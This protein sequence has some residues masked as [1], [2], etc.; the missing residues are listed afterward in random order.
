M[1][2]L[3]ARLANRRPWFVIAGAILFALV[4]GALGGS[5][6]SLLVGNGFA[7]PA[8]QSVAAQNRLQQATGVRA[9]TS[10]I[11]LVRTGQPIVSPVSRHE[12]ARVAGII[13][14]DPGIARVLTA[15]TAHD[16]R[17]V[18]RDGRGTYVEALF[19]PGSDEDKAAVRL[20]SRLAGDT[21]VQ[22]GGAAVANQEING[23]VSRDLGR[24]ELLAFPL[25]FLLLLWVFRG[26]VAASLPLI[27]G[28]LTILAAFLGLRIVVSFTPLSVYALNL[29]TGLGLGLSIDYSLFILSRF[30]EELAQRYDRHDAIRRTLAT[31]GR[32]V[33]FSSLTVGAALA[34]L[35]VFPERFLYS[36]G[37]GGVLV[38]LLASTMAL[39]VLPAVLVLLGTRVNSLAPRRWRRASETVTSHGFWWRLS[40]GVMRRPLPVAA[41][42]AVLLIALGLPALGIRFTSVDLSDLPAGSSARVVDRSLA[43]S[44]PGYVT[45]PVIVVAEAPLSHGAQV[46]ALARRLRAVPGL[47]SVSPPQPV[48]AGTWRIDATLRGTVFAAGS[49]D[50][51]SSIRSL[52]APFP[53][54]VGGSTANFV[55]L[56]ASLASHLP[57]AVLLIAGVSLV[58]LFLATGSVLLPIKSLLMNLLTLSAAY[59]LLVLVFQDG[60]LEGLLRYTG[61][62]AIE[63][64]QPILLFAIVFGLSTDYAVFLL[65]RIKE[66]HDGGVDTSQAVALGLERTGRIITAAALLF[67][68]AIGAFATSQIIFIKEL[69]VGTA[70]AVI[71]DATVVRALLVPSLMALLGRW[72][73]WAPSFLRRAHAAVGLDETRSEPEPVSA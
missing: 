60:R 43:A 47:A 29:V 26:L 62:G 55:D 22:L 69:G 34:S 23:I 32:T 44:F 6:S 1:L 13:A 37:I 8:S 59:G 2:Q 19:K 24:A 21:R 65:T 12:V 71:L 40:H 58:L 18:S 42:S 46:R 3:S 53:V 28:A 54:L 72:N 9:D 73:W 50:A 31:A 7:D 66:L 20:Q 27:A 48:G 11:A 16:P 30:R 45:S 52:P 57:L 33:L 56:Q 5:V 14:A 39:F 4:A 49:R 10:L 61:Q 15:Y 41:A 70:A 35:T 68:V 25:L 36:M 38:A 51:V 64:T 63:S 67:C 17:M